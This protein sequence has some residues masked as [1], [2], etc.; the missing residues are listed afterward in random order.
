ML[1]ETLFDGIPV[2]LLYAGTVLLLLAASELGFRL[3]RWRKQATSEG[4]KAPVNT[5]MGSTLALLAF[6]LAFTFGMSSARFDARKQ[7]AQEEASAILRAHQRAQFLPE[8]QRAECNRLLHEYVT[9]RLDIADQDAAEVEARVLRSEDLQDAL[10]QQATALS[11]QPSALLAGF[12]QSLSELVDLQLKRMRAVAWNRIPLTILCLLYGIAFLGLATIGY[13]GGLAD[14]RTSVPSVVLV[15][16]FAAVIVLIVDLER[17][18][19]DLFEVPRAPIH[20]TARRMQVLAPD[21]PGLPT[22]R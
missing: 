10:W 14:S 11:Q 5:M 20:E 3:G 21:S 12:M 8:P 9:L 19:Q 16:A 1:T 22:N 6:M 13:S 4:E 7:A 18:R 17:P 2:W 15:F